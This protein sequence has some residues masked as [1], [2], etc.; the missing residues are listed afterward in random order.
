LE[1]ESK[2]EHDESDLSLEKMPFAPRL[3]TRKSSPPM[4]VEHLEDVNC[5]DLLS[6]GITNAL[7]LEIGK[8]QEGMTTT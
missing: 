2:L 5:A 3:P 8:R 1:R 6:A 7:T 4:G